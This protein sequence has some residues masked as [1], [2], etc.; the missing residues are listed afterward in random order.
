MSLANELLKEI[1]EVE[2]QRR[3][4]QYNKVLSEYRK[5]FREK[6]S[7]LFYCGYIIYD[8]VRQRLERE[9]FKVQTVTYNSYGYVCYLITKKEDFSISE[10]SKSKITIE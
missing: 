8:E 3:E 5:N 9:G 2:E 6:G 1:D 4:E 7:V 10:E